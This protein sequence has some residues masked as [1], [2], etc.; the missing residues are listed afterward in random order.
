[1]ASDALANMGLRLQIPKSDVTKLKMCAVRVWML[2]VQNL[3]FEAFV[4]LSS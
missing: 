1:M 2:R 4:F 3:K